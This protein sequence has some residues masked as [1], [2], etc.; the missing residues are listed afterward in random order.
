MNL[1][2]HPVLVTVYFVYTLVLLKLITI[3]DNFL[4]LCH[5]PISDYC[6]PNEQETPSHPPPS[7]FLESLLLGS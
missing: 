6:N 4:I 5:Y 3:Q 2:V 1:R 7:P